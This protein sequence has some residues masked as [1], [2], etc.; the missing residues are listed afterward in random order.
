MTF[1]SLTFVVFLALTFAAYWATPSWTARKVLVLACSYVFYAAW[2]PFF[3][4]LII[5]TTGFDWFA[6]RWMD[7]TK[8]Q[9]RRQAIMAAAIAINL[10][11]LGF[12]RYA[13]FC[14]A[15]AV[16]LLRFFSV[17][18]KPL[19][20]GILLPVGISFYTFESPSYVIDVYRKRIEV[21]K[22][23][24]DYGLY[25]TF[26]PHLVAGPI[27]R[28]GDFAPQCRAPKPWRSTRAGRGLALFVYG[29]ALKVCLADLVFAPVANAV[30]GDAAEAG[31]A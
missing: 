17:V 10:S 7:R 20:L 8:A 3:V 29:V 22:S 21:S 16:N 25:V 14:A 12:L 6:A 9:S 19:S 11:A 2:N 26:F 24:L 13:H 28:Y 23:L 31:F 1:D 27:L 4:L 15:N 5:A 18:F 30:F